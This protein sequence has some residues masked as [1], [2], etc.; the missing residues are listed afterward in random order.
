MIRNLKVLFGAMLALAAFGV[1]SASGAQAA[2][3]HCSV[4][5]CTFRLNPDGEGKNAHHVFIIDDLTTGESVSFTCPRLTGEGTTTTKTSSEITVTNLN[6]NDEVNGSK[7]NVVNGAKIN[8]DMMGCDYDFTAAGQVFV[9]CP[10]PRASNRIRIEKTE[11]GAC[12]Y[13]VPDQGPLGTVTY[14]TIGSEPNREVTVSTNVVGI[15]VSMTG[16][17]AGCL[18]K[19]LSDNFEGR[20]TTGNTKVT[21][22][23]DP[24]ES[25]ADG[26]WL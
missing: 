1:V 22:E 10:E 9:R 8:V 14:T 13:E 23:T 26:W 15:Q 12:T 3:F 2:E 5:P 4:A 6:Y 20:Y 21:A 24:G 16:T 17:P 7:C 18:V 11:G 19:S 25:M